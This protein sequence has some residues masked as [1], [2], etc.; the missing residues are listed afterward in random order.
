MVSAAMPSSAQTA[1][2]VT[3]AYGEPIVS[4]A[5]TA[6]AEKTITSPNSTSRSTVPNIH[7][8]TPT[9]FAICSQ[10]ASTLQTANQL[11]EHAPAVFIV[12]K[13]VE[14][15]ARRRQQHHIARASR[16]RCGTHG[17]IE[18]SG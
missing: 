17:C 18:R 3:K 14:T 6:E 4:L 9:R 15:C 10:T 13:L 11:L 5:I 16:L 12:L 8:S 2:L 7:L 1:C